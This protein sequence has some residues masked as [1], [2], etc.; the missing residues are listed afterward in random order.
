MEPSIVPGG[1]GRPVRGL[2]ARSLSA[3]GITG[4]GELPKAPLIHWPR[5]HGWGWLS[6]Q[7]G[8]SS[9][10]QDPKKL[11][12]NSLSLPGR[13]GEKASY[14]RAS[15]NSRHKEPQEDLWLCQTRVF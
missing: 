11:K 7:M 5:W 10:G 9:E 13:G 2:Q 15:Q 6:K 4:S 8:C 3:Y 12:T 1:G 14:N